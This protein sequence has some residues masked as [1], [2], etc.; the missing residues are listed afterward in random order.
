MTLDWRRNSRETPV[1]D[2]QR[3]ALEQLGMRI[4]YESAFWASGHFEN[5]V[6]VVHNFVLIN[7]PPEMLYDYAPISLDDLLAHRCA[8]SPGTACIINAFTDHPDATPRVVAYMQK[9]RIKHA[10]SCHMVDATSGLTTAISLWRDPSMEPFDEASRFFFEQC[11]PHLIDACDANRIFHMER[12]SRTDPAL[13]AAAVAD[14]HGLLHLAPADFQHRMQIEW[15]DWRGPRVP[16]PLAD[17][18]SALEPG[19]QYTGERT[20]FRV[21]PMNDVLLIQARCRQ[22]ADALSPREHEVARLMIAGRTRKE[23]AQELGIAP[24]TVRNH[25]SAIFAKLG[26]RKQSEL[27]NVLRSNFRPQE[28][29]EVERKTI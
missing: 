2:F 18:L 25:L 26:I 24:A 6:P 5:G 9:W 19:T 1:E 23:A 13:Y 27:A 20:V 16:R 8:A 10:I 22:P 7:R 4:P 28:V 12:A 14:P 21:T 17:L 15:P 3:F 29:S 11:V